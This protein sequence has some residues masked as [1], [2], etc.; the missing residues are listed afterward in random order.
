M[1]RLWVRGLRGL[2]VYRPLPPPNNNNY[3]VRCFLM[4]LQPHTEGSGRHRR[5]A[6]RHSP[7]GTLRGASPP[8]SMAW[9]V[10]PET[11]VIRWVV[12]APSAGQ[13]PP[14]PRLP[15]ARGPHCAQGCGKRSEA[16]LSLVPPPQPLRE[17]GGPTPRQRAT[18]PLG[19]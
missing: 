10:T 6:D 16:E 5:G 14:P 18:G 15:S 8:G 9:W 7:L 3:P 2:R 12:M 19:L 4:K 17:G 13:C 11:E 1:K